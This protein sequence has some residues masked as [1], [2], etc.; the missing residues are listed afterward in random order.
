ME[1][2]KTVQVVNLF[3]DVVNLGSELI[4][5]KLGE[6]FYEHLSEQQFRLLDILLR[7]GP[8]LPT[9]LATLQGVQ[10]SAISN[11]L[12][13]LQ[14]KKLIEWVTAT[15]D[16]RYKLVQITEEGERILSKRNAAIF[17]E[18]GKLLQ[19]LDEEQIDK[20]I[21]IFTTFKEKLNKK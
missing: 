21:E 10:K 5:V 19:N 11:R 12:K 3:E 7:K 9:A 13:K 2:K 1:D 8:S 18:V 16:K 4:N 15:H 6:N 14:N 20:V 17:N